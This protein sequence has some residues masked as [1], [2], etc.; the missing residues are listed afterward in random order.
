MSN[1]AF[2]ILHQVE[3]HHDDRPLARK[4]DSTGC[5]IGRARARCA[6]PRNWSPLDPRR[7]S[8]PAALDLNS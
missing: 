6:R 7:I 2:S 8:G 3:L 1:D 5:W 4:L